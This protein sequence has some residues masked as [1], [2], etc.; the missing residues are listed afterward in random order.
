MK[1][2]GQQA[3]PLSLFGMLPSPLETCHPFASPRTAEP[4]PAPDRQLFG[5]DGGITAICGEAVSVTATDLV[6]VRGAF[7]TA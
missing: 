4:G 6:A 5:T 2:V 1:A 3:T 7:V